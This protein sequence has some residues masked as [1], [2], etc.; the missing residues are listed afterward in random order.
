MSWQL[1]ILRIQESVYQKEFALRSIKP[2]AAL[3]DVINKK[4]DNI[5]GTELKAKGYIQ[6]NYNT[7]LQ[8]YTDGSKDQGKSLT[9]CAF[10]IPD[11]RVT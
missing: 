7:A 3:K 4:T 11:I 6:K 1:K 5:N 10:T 8:I 2:K 9:G